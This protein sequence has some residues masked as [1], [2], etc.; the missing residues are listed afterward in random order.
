MVLSTL[1]ADYGYV[2]LAA[3]AT[4]F[5]NFW[6][7]RKIGGLRKS[8]GIKYPLMY[9]EKH[10]EFN[11][12]QRVHQ[13]TLENIPFFLVTLLLGGLRHPC[14]AGGFGG[15]FLV[16][17]VIYSLGYYSGQPEKRIPGAIITML[18]ALLPLTCLSI[19]TA[20]G[21]LGWF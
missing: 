4:V 17:R 7:M 21:L 3:S 20:A 1:H 16:G 15:V 5:L 18:G 6:Q 13:N 14:L 11:C 9:S 10:P 19:S 12:A 2:I 8:L